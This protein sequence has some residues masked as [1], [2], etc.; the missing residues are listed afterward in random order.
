[1]SEIKLNKLDSINYLID[2]RNDLIDKRNDLIENLNDVLKVNDS[3]SEKKSL[4]LLQEIFKINSQIK[5]PFFLFKYQY[6]LI[7]FPFSFLLV[8][9]LSVCYYSFNG[10]CLRMRG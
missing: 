10:F 6:H 9:L 1:M 8:S 5:T 2:K 3:V 7:D 4:E